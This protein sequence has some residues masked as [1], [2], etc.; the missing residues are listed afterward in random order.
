MGLVRPWF[1]NG[2]Q[3]PTDECLN[4]KTWQHVDHSKGFGGIPPVCL[5]TLYLE[6]SNNVTEQED[7]PATPPPTASVKATINVSSIKWPNNTWEDVCKDLWKV[8]VLCPTVD[9]FIPLILTSSISNWLCH[10]CLPCWDRC[11]VYSASVYGR[12]VRVLPLWCK[13]WTHCWV[14]LQHIGFK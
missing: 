1:T 3:S 8:W 10:S 5:S 11:R 13:L 9:V 12:R 14:V 6:H 7:L 2:L 4:I